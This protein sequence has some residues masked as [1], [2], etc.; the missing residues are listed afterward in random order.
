MLAIKTKKEAH[1]IVGGLSKPSKMPG[2]SIGLPAWECKTGSKL[3]DVPGS[4]CSSCYAMKGFYTVYPEVKAAQYRRLEAINDI[5]W[6]PAMVKLIAGQEVFRWHDAGDIQNIVHLENIVRVVKATPE[7]KHWM[8]TK[9]KQIIKQFL[10]KHKTFPNNM[11]VR[12]SGAMVNGK[13]LKSFPYTSTVSNNGQSYGHECPAPTQGGECKDCR[14]CWSR[15]V[16][17]V[18]YHQH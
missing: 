13:P 5:R 2:F 4:V 3:R 15:E 7:T 1:Q 14:A 10:K 16:T 6:V 11:V 8:P 9:E 12:V 18:T 17:N